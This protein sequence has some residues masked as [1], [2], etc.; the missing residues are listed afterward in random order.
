MPKSP[1]VRATIPDS[2][3]YTQVQDSPIHGRG[4][5]ARR[6]IRAGQRLLEYKGERID[7]PEA[8]RRHPHDPAQPNHT[9]YF[10]LGDATVIDGGVQ[11]NSARWINHSCAPNCE[12]QQIGNRV[13]ID[14]L[15]DIAPG[16]ELF[17][18]YALELD[19]RYTAKLKRDYA[20]RCGAPNCRGTLL[21][22]KT[23]KRSA[24]A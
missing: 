9:F 10:S 15:R 8:L 19:A 7:W 6:P 4:V 5:F 2:G 22:P 3:P 18:D 13:F 21:A 23:R 12:A 24:K 1:P 11:G 16:E 20:C 14:A 17:F